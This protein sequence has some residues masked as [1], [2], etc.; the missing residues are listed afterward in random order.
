MHTCKER[1]WKMCVLQFLFIIYHTRAVKRIKC[2][3]RDLYAGS[4]PK[5]EIALLLQSACKAETPS[6]AEKREP[7]LRPT[8]RVL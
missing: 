1:T 2:V 4:L 3:A 5:D 8:R 7:P 6:S